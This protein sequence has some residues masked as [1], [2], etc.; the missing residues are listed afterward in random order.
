MAALVNSRLDPLFWRPALVDP[1]SAL[2]GHIPFAHWLVRAIAPS[3]IVE[4][5]T[6]VGVSYLAFCNAVA[7]ERLGTR[8]FAIDTWRGDEQSGFY[9]EEVF[10]RFAS[11]HDQHFAAFSTLLRSTFDDALSL[12]DSSSVD[13]LHMDGLHTYEAVRHDFEAWQPKLSNCAVVLMHDTNERRE[14][15]GV[16]RLWAELRQQFPSFEFQHGHGLGVLATGTNVPR[17]LA[18]LFAQRNP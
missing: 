11:L 3:V 4:L 16:W 1:L 15:F 6:H 18:G 5:G 14:N 17:G 7:R 8:C 10:K 9:G 2:C 12:I 13:L